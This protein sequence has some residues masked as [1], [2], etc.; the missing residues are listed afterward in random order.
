MGPTW[1][2]IVATF[3]ISQRRSWLT[4]TMILLQRVRALKRNMSLLPSTMDLL[5]VYNQGIRETFEDLGLRTTFFV[6]GNTASYIYSEANVEKLRS[7]HRTDP[8]IASHTRSHSSL[9]SLDGPGIREEILQLEVAFRKILGI[10]P[11]HMRT[12]FGNFNKA[13]L[14]GMGKLDDQVNF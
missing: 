5:D 7:A 12:P 10:Q 14:E 4:K 9:T 13:V 8:H 6:N 11:K 2:Q 3:S 1:Q